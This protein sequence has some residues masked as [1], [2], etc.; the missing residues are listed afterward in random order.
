MH[1]LQSRYR[2]CSSVLHMFHMMYQKECASSVVMCLLAFP[3]MELLP[4]LVILELKLCFVNC[5]P[6]CVSTQVRHR[7]LS[8]D[9]KLIDSLLL[10]D[11]F[12]DIVPY[13]CRGGLRWQLPIW[14]DLHG[15]MNEW[16]KRKNSSSVSLDSAWQWVST[17]LKI[18]QRKSNIEDT[19]LFYGISYKYI[20]HSHF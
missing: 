2:V 7:L 10:L 18:Q 13:V 11:S 1:K 14:Q 5:N 3:V 4:D 17:I 20:S 6:V 8:V 15:N 19:L 12:I 9:T 16:F